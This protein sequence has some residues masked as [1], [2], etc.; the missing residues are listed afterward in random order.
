MELLVLHLTDLHLI[1]EIDYLDNKIS[2]ISKILNGFNI[3]NVLILFSGDIANSG[4]AEQ[5]AKAEQYISKIVEELSRNKSVKLCLCPGNHDRLFDSKTQ[6]NGSYVVGINK[7]NYNA[8][9]EKM[10]NSIANYLSFEKRLS[11]PTKYLNDVMSYYDVHYDDLNIRVYSLNNSLLSTFKSDSNDLNRNEGNI[12][13]RGQCFDIHR[14]NK[15]FVFLLMHMP[16]SFFREDNQQYI[17]NSVSKEFDVILSGHNHSDQTKSIINSNGRVLEYTSSAIDYKNMSGFSLLK[18]SEGRIDCNL[19]EYDFG[20]NAYVKKAS[21]LRTST[22]KMIKSTIFGQMMSDDAVEDICTMSV[23]DGEKNI[24]VSVSDLFVFPK[25]SYQKY[26]NQ[27]SVSSFDLLE[28]K[29]AANGITKI[30]G[31]YKSGKTTLCKYLFEK[32]RKNGYLPIIVRGDE[33]LDPKKTLRKQLKSLYSRKNTL[34]DFESVEKSKRI[35]IIDDLRKG[36]RLF[37]RNLL[38][39]FGSV[40]Y[41]TSSSKDFD[42]SEEEDEKYDFETFEIEP[43]FYDKRTSLYE[44]IYHY[45]ATKNSTLL[46]DYSYDSLTSEIEKRLTEL[47]FSNCINPGELVFITFT[48]VKKSN[49]AINSPNSIFRARLQTLLSNGLREE[50]Y[51]YCTSDIAEDLL[52]YVAME[53]Y[54]EEKNTFELHLLKTSINKYEEE[55][56]FRPIKNESSFAELL[57]DIQIFKQNENDEWSF[58]DRKVFAYFVAKYAVVKK[59]SDNDDRYLKEIISRGIYKPI[60]LYILFSIATNYE[61]RS[62]PEFY[63]NE[64]YDSV[65]NKKEISYDIFQR[66]IDELNENN[67]LKEL[68]I[69]KQKR[70]EVREKQGVAEENARKGFVTHKDDFFFYDNSKQ[71]M[72]EFDYLL[73][74]T[75]ITSSI[76]N[77]FAGVLKKGTRLK[78]T[79]MLIKLPYSIIDSFL[80]DTMSKLDIVFVRV[81]DQLSRL[82]EIKVTYEY[83]KNSIINEIHAS[84][85]AIFDFDTRLLTNPL[86]TQSVKKLLEEKNDNMHDAHKLML[87]S[88][89]TDFDEYVRET[90]NC[91]SN[92]SDRFIIRSA[93]LIGR[94]FC[95]DN[96]DWVE[97]N[98]GSFLTLISKGND[99]EI[100]RIR[101]KNLTRKK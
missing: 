26:N 44:K 29:R 99:T 64:L 25:L 42:L 9:V 22:I 60:N 13:V 38:K 85:L 35:I 12:F 4:E 100:K 51:K 45:F 68:E 5:Y 20:E 59:N 17:M 30:Q 71:L 31:D 8:E 74:V 47:D 87:L 43:F 11:K 101:E 55:H 81:F 19:Y 65:M 92:S 53:L 89:S 52:S 57:K 37:F 70:R 6:I 48:I 27:S 21:D 18:I 83:V 97:K 7:S 91:I 98:K 36:S 88:F 82:P 24:K 67:E 62:I 79:E 39:L 32:Y 46:S 41:T 75:M 86:I 94:R 96:L 28:S 61:Y 34:E 58:F 15:D 69:N 14:E 95:L 40:I 76:L 49:L 2:S 66:F 3:D 63:V 16:F 72:V 80:S 77:N 73:N 93:R 90:E 23:F 84:I 1:S 33:I 10:K 56:G 54:I 50:G 78:L